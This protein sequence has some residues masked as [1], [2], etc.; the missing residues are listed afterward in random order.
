MYESKLNSWAIRKFF[1][2]HLNLLQSNFEWRQ[3]SKQA[4]ASSNSTKVNTKVCRLETLIK[5]IIAYNI[6]SNLCIVI[7][8]ELDANYRDIRLMDKFIIFSVLDL[9]QTLT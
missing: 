1:C 5:R 7:L 4:L 2:V 9:T 3:V 6:T 8:T